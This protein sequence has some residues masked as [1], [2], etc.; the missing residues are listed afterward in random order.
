[1]IKI[2]GKIRYYW[3]PEISWAIIYWSVTFVPLFV[4]L[5]LLLE[6]LRLSFLFL[7]LISLFLLLFF[8]GSNRYFELREKEL[9]IM[10]ANPFAIQTIAI[11]TISKVE[12]SY[13]TIRIYT[14]DLP[15]G[16]VYYMG[17]WPKKYF[18]NH[19]ALHPSFSGEMELVDHLIAQDYFE[20]YYTTKAKSLR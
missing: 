18:I 20:E 9:R 16:Q 2:F 8:L 17:K 15:D 6:K 19:L 3:Q 4:S 12:I 1:M 11:E 7:F 14:K 10:S 13:L 5:T